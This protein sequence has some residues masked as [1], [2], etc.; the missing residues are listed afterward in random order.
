MP[1]ERSH[2]IDLVDGVRIRI[3]FRT[4]GNIVTEFLVQLETLLEDEWCGIVRYDSA[5]GKPHIDT[6]DRWGREIDKQWL[7]GTFNEALTIGVSDVR[8]RWQYYL[9]QFIGDE[10][11]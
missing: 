7:D 5:H 10:R 3:R 1:N 9:D 2:T 4:D 11:S 6:L 8:D